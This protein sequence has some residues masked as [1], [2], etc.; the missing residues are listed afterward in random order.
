MMLRELEA[1]RLR[2]VLIPAPD[3]RHSGHKIRVVE[4]RNPAWYRELCANYLTHRSR[5]HRRRPKFVDT[6]I[7]RRNVL[8]ALAEISRG[9]GKYFER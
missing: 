1:T 3:R 5:P 7:K 2:V 8:R 4:Q 6:L 9:G